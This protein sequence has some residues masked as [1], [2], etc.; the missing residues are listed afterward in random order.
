MDKVDKNLIALLSENSRVSTSELSRKLGVSRSTVQGRIDRLLRNKIVDRFTIDLNPDHERS[1]IKAHVL[2][3]VDQ[4]L[5]GRAQSNLQ[6]LSEITA[7]YS[8]S[9]E[10]DMIVV[11]AARSTSEL[12]SL[13]DQIAALDG[14]VRTNSSVILETRLR[15]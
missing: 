10:Y 2:I 7:I 3:K 15:R 11:A 9:G 14:V 8:V 4:Q 5:T 1:L 6:R 12:N 13:L